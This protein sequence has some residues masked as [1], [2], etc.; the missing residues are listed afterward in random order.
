MDIS[1]KV[2]NSRWVSKLDVGVRMTL[3]IPD[4]LVLLEENADRE[5]EARVVDIRGRVDHFS[6]GSDAGGGALDT[7]KDG[8]SCAACFTFCR[9]VGC[10]AIANCL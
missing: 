10:V 2:K 3:T 6:H 5:A 4:Y 7:G 9:L 1:L 8:Y